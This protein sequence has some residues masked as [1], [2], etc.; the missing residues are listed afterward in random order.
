MLTS[1]SNS[2]HNFARVDAKAAD[3]LVHRDD[4]YRKV[5]SLVEG[6]IG[7][8]NAALVGPRVEELPKWR[9]VLGR[10]HTA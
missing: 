10:R 7:N 5:I 1:E 8:R 3:M 6:W 2:I 4:T 9:T